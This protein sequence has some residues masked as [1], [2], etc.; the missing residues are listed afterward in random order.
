[1]SDPLQILAGCRAVVDSSEHV[2]I[3]GGALERAADEIV[4]SGAVPE[5]DA[6]LHYRATGPDGDERT[7]MWLLVLDALNFCFWPQGEDRDERWRVR[8]KGELVDGYVALV[9][10]LTN[11]IDEG[12]PLHDASWLA[13][14]PEEDVAR[15]LVPEPGHMEIPLMEHRVANLRELGQGLLLLGDNPATSLIRS[16]NR[17][18]I[19]LVEMIVDMFPSFNDVTVWPYSETGVSTN[20]VRF[21][22]RAQ[23]LIG[24]LAGGLTGSPLAEFDD[25]DQLTAFADYKVPQILREMGVLVYGDEL[26]SV[27]DSYTH[28]PQGDR[29]EVEIRAATLVACDLLVRALHNRGRGVTAAELDWHLWSLSQELGRNHRPYHRTVTVFY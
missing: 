11:A 15:F 5:W 21:Y 18:A 26:A 10:A 16:A 23:I 28:I 17:S 24:D 25:L 12:Y 27:V 6:D 8:W 19:R 1:M 20:E 9:A 2:R 4:R 29:L 22:K 7:A 3:D 14:V 13:N